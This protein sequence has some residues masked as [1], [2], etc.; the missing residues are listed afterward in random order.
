[1][2]ALCAGQLLLADYLALLDR[3]TPL[4]SQTGLDSPQH[5]QGLIRQVHEESRLD[6]VRK[7][8]E[9]ELTSAT[10]GV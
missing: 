7:Y 4:V 3:V 1:V 10:F 2:Y 6:P 8:A 9:V 5:W